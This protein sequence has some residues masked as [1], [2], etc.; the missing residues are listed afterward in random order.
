[1]R[2]SS[3]WRMI[4]NLDAADI[5]A[6]VLIFIAIIGFIW[7]CSVASWVPMLTEGTIINKEYTPARHTSGYI[8]G[9]YHSNSQQER[10]KLLVT[11]GNMSEWWYVTEDEYFHYHVGD[12][13]RK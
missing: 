5:T 3:I 1:M 7:I 2:R 11:D 12:Y 6:F 9:Q 8:G 4:R 13:I 10:F